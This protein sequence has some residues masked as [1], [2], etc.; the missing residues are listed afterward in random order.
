MILFDESGK[1]G[2][3]FSEFLFA[4]NY[5]VP[6][7]QC[8]GLKIVDFIAENGDKQ[9]FIEVKNYAGTSD[10]AAILAAMEKRQEIDYRMLSDPTAAFPLEMGM[11]FK[12][13]LLRWLASGNELRKPVILLLVI[14]PPSKLKPNE[15]M[16]LINRINGY[17]P[18]GI[19]AKPERYP[20]MKP[21]FFDMPTVADVK[22]RYGFSVTVQA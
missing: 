5:D 18:I 19:N 15:R 17:I 13:S 14:N 4:E 21:V 6:E 9:F 11:K 3:D 1:L 20:K 16:K 2:F 22:E 7:W 8:A 12:D 10:N